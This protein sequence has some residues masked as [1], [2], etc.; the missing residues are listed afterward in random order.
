MRQ[1]KEG[2][3]RFGY[4]DVFRASERSMEAQ[5]NLEGTQGR[6]E[7]I[8]LT[9]VWCLSTFQSGRFWLEALVPGFGR[10]VPNRKRAGFPSIFC[11]T[12]SGKPLL[13]FLCPA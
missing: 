5:G 10:A 13:N 8:G 6:K 4:L 3:E 9:L 2:K 1:G 12:L 11:P 7:V